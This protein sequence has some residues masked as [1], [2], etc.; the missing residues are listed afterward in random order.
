MNLLLHSRL[1]SSRLTNK[2]GNLHN[3]RCSGPKTWH[4]TYQDLSMS[5]LRANNYQFLSVIFI[6]A[7]SNSA[8]GLSTCYV[9]LIILTDICFMTLGISLSLITSFLLISR[10]N[11]LH[12]PILGRSYTINKNIDLTMSLWMK[13]QWIRGFKSRWLR[14]VGLQL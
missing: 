2:Y 6:R 8:W 13:W 7:V 3:R 10:S 14:E 12:R 11:K 1:L 5:S 9:V 4:Q